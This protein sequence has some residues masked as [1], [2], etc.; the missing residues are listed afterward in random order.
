M[1]WEVDAATW[2]LQEIGR[3]FSLYEVIV[4]HDQINWLKIR[5]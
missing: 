3:L 5:K 1:G 4:K 2:L